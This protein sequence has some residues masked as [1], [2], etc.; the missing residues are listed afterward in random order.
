MS[1]SFDVL[2]RAAALSAG[3]CAASIAL[4]SAV[5]DTLTTDA[6][7][8]SAAS[9]PAQQRY[10]AI[11]DLGERSE[12]ASQVV[13]QLMKMLAD[14]DPQIRWRTARTLGEYEG[15]AQAAA[16]GIR[17][18]LTDSDPVVQYHA[19]VAL[20]KLEDKSDATVEAL[21]AAATSKDARVALRCDLGHSQP[22]AWAEA[23]SRSRGQSPQVE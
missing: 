1:R 18:L 13:P 17:K 11:D 23:G 9:G 10:T 22:A 5:V 3:L 21:V 4:S 6:M 19:A 12:D 20:G 8:K 15:Q 7:L 16:E 14:S 2:R